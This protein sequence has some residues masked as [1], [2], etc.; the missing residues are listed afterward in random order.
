MRTPRLVLSA[1][2]IWPSLLSSRKPKR[3]RLAMAILEQS[4]LQS[5]CVLFWQKPLLQ[6]LVLKFTSQPGLGTAQKPPLQ[7]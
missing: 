1:P 5:V 7:S 4:T 3:D 6:L 2:V